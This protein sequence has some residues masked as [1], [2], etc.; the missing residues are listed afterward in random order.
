MESLRSFGEIYFHCIFSS[1]VLLVNYF[2]TTVYGMDGRIPHHSPL[3]IINVRMAPVIYLDVD[4]Y[5]SL[6]NYSIYPL[7]TNSNLEF[8]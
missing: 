6:V 7:S 2:S 1:N 8:G 4:S 3:K 5:T